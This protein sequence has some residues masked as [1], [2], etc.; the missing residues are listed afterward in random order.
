MSLKFWKWHGLGNDFLLLREEDWP[1]G[2]AASSIRR[3]ADRHRGVGFDQLLVI[4]AQSCR[5]RIYNADGST[6]EQC[7]NGLRCV[8]AWLFQQGVVQHASFDVFS[9][10]G[11]HAVEVHDDGT[12]S[13]NMGEPRV[14]ESL[15]LHYAAR[16][17][18]LQAVDIGNPHAVVRVGEADSAPL[19]ALAAAVQAL[20]RF[21]GGVNVGVLTVSD[22]SHANLLVHERGSGATQACGSGACAAMVAARVNGWLD[23]QAS[24]CQPGGE[25]QLRWQGVGSD[26]WMRGPATSVFAGELEAERF[27]D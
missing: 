22:R 6:A 23:A 10:A 20:G 26:L 3:L 17:W 9:P 5:F 18:Q 19:E 1:D 21:P 24:V 12:V 2:W 25:L 11:S 16:E 8:A 27:L 13:A 4:D 7:G 14:G 15:A